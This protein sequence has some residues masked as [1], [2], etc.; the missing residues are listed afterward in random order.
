LVTAAVALVAVNRDKLDPAILDAWLS[1][2][3]FW[4]PLA[5]VAVYAVGT[6]VFAPGALFALAGGAMFGPVFGTFL[7]LAGA[8]IGASIAFLI[9]RYVAGEWVKRKAGGKLK[10]LLD[11]VES[12]GW[13]FVAFVRLVP[14]FPFNLSN[15]AFGLTRIPFA[16]YVVTSFV[17]MAPGALA[18]TWLGYAGREALGGNGSAIR[19]GLLALG[20][21]AAIAFLPRMIGRLRAGAVAW[22]EPKDLLGMTASGAPLTI[23]DVRGR[24]EFTGPLGHIPGAI[25]IPLDEIGARRDAL[26]GDPGAVVALVCRT[27]R[28]SA[29]AARQLEESGLAEARVLHGGMERWNS[30]GFEVAHTQ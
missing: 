5:Y 16:A 15:Y 8:T 1:G 28:R 29:V 21:L 19:Y 24:D 20:I 27:D 9:A 26:L 7:N 13:R 12:E 10:R 30:L 4:A 6:V 11:G 17:T 22:I 23:V 25:N 18:Y 14:L 3:G 2:M